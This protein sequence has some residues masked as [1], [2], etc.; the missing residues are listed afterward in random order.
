MKKQRKNDKKVKPEPQENDLDESST[1][2]EKAALSRQLAEEHK[3]EHCGK[4]FPG[5]SSLTAHQVT[6]TREKPF[7][8]KE[9]GKF[10][11]SQGALYNHGGVH[12][13]FKCDH[14]VKLFAQKA[15]LKNH[16][17]NVHTN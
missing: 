5:K 8:C 2:D 1:L 14:C 6:H 9:C 4:G 7:E 3:C 16:I 11:S 12:N 13:P 15:S 10:F 17:H